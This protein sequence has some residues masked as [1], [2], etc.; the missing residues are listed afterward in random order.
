MVIE[1]LE[2]DRTEGGSDTDTPES[3]FRPRVV[4]NRVRW[5]TIEDGHRQLTHL[6]REGS[7][8]DLCQ[9]TPH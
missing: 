8:S 9:G 7:S 5:Y 2:T 3:L 6:L 1:I 4:T